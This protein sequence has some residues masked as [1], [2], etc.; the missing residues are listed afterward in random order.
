MTGFD[1]RPLLGAA[2]DQ[3]G[4]IIATVTPAQA[5]L[6]TPCDEYDVNQLIGHMQAVVR[7]IGVV[8][9]GE[10]FWSV[11][12]ELESTDWTADWAAGRAA[13]ELSLADDE[14]LIREVT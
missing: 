9:S 13:T 8:L 6:P 2:L 5:N 14:C 11:P 7:R 3:A 4:A 1:P 10:P 12:R